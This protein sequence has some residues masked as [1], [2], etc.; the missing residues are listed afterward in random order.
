MAVREVRPHLP[1]PG[2]PVRLV[3]PFALQP[4]S[5]TDVRSRSS[6]IMQLCVGDYTNQIWLSGFNDVGVALL[7]KTADAIEILQK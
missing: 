5:G 6:F 7:G 4:D 3:P 2:V 1:S